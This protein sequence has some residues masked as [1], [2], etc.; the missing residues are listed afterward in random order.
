ML[1]RCKINR[2]EALPRE[3]LERNPASRHSR[4]TLTVGENYTALS[5]CIYEKD[6]WVLTLDDTGK[7]NWHYLALFADSVGP[8]PPDW[9]VSVSDAAGT[10][11]R[12]LLMGYRSMVEDPGHHEGLI[13]RR[14]Q[15]LKQFVEAIRP[16]QVLPREGAALERLRN[17]ISEWQTRNDADR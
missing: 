13:D 14:V 4:F 5:L 3:F 7:P 17:V 15:S 10:T 8:V 6:P 2:G 16:A 1:L 11:G 9:F 12:P